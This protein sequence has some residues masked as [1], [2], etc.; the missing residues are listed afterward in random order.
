[1]GPAEQPDYVNAVACLHTALDAHELLD[2]LHAI[3]RDHGRERSA[4]RW[5]PRTLDLDLLV[6]GR[7]V[8]DHPLLTVP[9]PGIAER[10]F[11]LLPLFEIAPDLMIPGHG[12]LRTLLPT[13]VTNTVH[14]IESAR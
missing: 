12:S 6:Y 13:C 5:G 4:L 9:H 10:P 14:R 2:A 11:V 8:V 1:M 3:E 7:L